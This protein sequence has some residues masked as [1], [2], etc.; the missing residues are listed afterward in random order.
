MLDDF[1][2][3]SSSLLTYTPDTASEREL[4]RTITISSDNI[5][6]GNEIFELAVSTSDV[7]V[8]VQQAIAIVVIVDETGKE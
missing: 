8:D 4:C 7:A 6:E 2:L 5:V 3:P 1:Q